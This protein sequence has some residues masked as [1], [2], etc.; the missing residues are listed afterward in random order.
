M[1]LIHLNHPRSLGRRGTVLT[2]DH[3]RVTLHP[4]APRTVI[5][6]PGT[7]LLFP[8]SYAGPWRNAT[9]TAAGSNL[10]EIEK[11]STSYCDDFVC[12]SSPALE[13]TVRSFARGLELLRLPPVLFAKDVEFS[14][15]LRSF[16]GSA[17]Y[18]R[19]RFILDNVQNPKVVSPSLLSPSNNHADVSHA[20]AACPM[21]LTR[22]CDEVRLSMTSE[23][24]FLTLACVRSG[25][26]EAA[27]DQYAQRWWQQCGF[28]PSRLAAHRHLRCRPNR[29]WDLLS[30]RDEPRHREDP[31]TQVGR[32]PKLL[33]ETYRAKNLR[34]V[35]DLRCV[36]SQSPP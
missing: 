15:G 8:R 3:P 17:G 21:S 32:G 36:S 10:P 31:L 4:L 9:S 22:Q 33:P 11:L 34:S 20:W 26:R 1:R 19:L 12:T 13:Q 29:R 6:C 27:D 30:D 24:V 14:D 23:Y 25:H 35:S 7:I 28:R 16:K 5:S 18:A 2:M